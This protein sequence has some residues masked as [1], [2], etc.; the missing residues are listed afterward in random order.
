MVSTADHARDVEAKFSA[1]PAHVQPK[2][3]ALRK[4]VLSLEKEVGLITETLKWGEPAYQTKRGSTVRFDWKERAP[5]SIAIYFIC[6]TQLV[7]TFQEVYGDL[8]QYEGNR[9]LIFPLKG[10]LPAGPVKHCLSVALRYHSVK[11]LPLLS[12]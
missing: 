7:E 12:M 10:R 4:L 9:A 3:R 2:M 1:Y 6:S 11:H 8:F 5:T